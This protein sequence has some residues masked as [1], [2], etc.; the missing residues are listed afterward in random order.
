M[1]REDILNELKKFKVVPHKTI[2]INDL[3]DKQ[4]EL[5]LNLFKIMSD[6]GDRALKD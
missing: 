2:N 1:K 3:T 5:R 4:L 6:A